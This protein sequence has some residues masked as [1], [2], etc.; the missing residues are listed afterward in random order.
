[1]HIRFGRFAH[2]FLRGNFRFAVGL[3]IG[4]VGFG[5]FCGGRGYG[6]GA[7][8]GVES[9]T[10]LSICVA[11]TY[12]LCADMYIPHRMRGIIRVRGYIGNR[13]RIRYQDTYTG[14]WLIET[15]NFA[16]SDTEHTF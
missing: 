13:Y 8:G 16:T 12:I 11:V 2:R 7:R 3:S 5:N 9:R 14:Y 6:R 15:R 1:M 4:R 10:N